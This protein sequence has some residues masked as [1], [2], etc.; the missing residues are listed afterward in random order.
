MTDD[1]EKAELIKKIALA[2]SLAQADKLILAQME[3]C[4][5]N[6]RK[7]EAAL[8]KFYARGP[9]AKKRLGRPRFWKSPDGLS[10]VWE[11][12]RIKKERKCKTTATAIRAAKKQLIR[13]GQLSK[14]SEAVAARLAKLTDKELQI[15]YHDARN[16]W[17]FVVDPEAYN[18]EREVLERNVDQALTAWRA[19]GRSP[20][21]LFVTNSGFS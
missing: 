3:Q 2:E 6:F 12:E 7:A 16:F 17:R 21:G 11:V 1:P 19:V 5:A 15:R 8:S 14:T 10:F 20:Y 13:Q 4:A 9:R 18:R